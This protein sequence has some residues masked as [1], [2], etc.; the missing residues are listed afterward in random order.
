VVTLDEMRHL[1]DIRA[2]CED[3]QTLGFACFKGLRAVE[4]HYS[5]NRVLR[6]Q[7]EMPDGSFADIGLEQA[8]DEIAAHLAAIRDENG[9][10]AIAGYKGGGGFFTSSAVTLMIEWLQG[11]G[12]PKSYSSATIDQSAKMVTAGR[13]GLW[14]PGK[15]VVSDC[16]VMM[17]LGTN[18]LVS[19]N[20]PFD[21]R[22]P[23]KRMKEA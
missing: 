16:D 11:L 21:V 4:A 20:P 19:Q 1:V 22:N 2:D 23:V 7:K 9:P 10:E 12:S 15:P 8:L 18:P 17:L 6:P 3:P 14:P 13:I 5:A